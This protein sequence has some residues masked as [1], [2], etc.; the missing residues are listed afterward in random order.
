MYAL[1]EQLAGTPALGMAIGQVNQNPPLTPPGQLIGAVDPWWGAG[2]FVY[3]YAAAAIPA[4]QLCNIR[5]SFQ[6]NQYRFDASPTPNVANLGGDVAVAME[7]LAAG[8][9]GWFCVAGVVPVSSTAAVA[10]AAAIGLAAAGQLGA[11]SAGKQLLNASCLGSSATT[12]VKAN[13][14]A[15]PGTTLLQ[16]PNSDGWFPGVYLSGTGIAAGTTVLSVDGSGRYVTLSTATTASVAGSVTATYNNAVIFYNLVK[17]N[18]SFLQG[19]ITCS[20]LGRFGK[21]PKRTR[22]WGLFSFRRVLWRMQD[23]TSQATPPVCH[24]REEDRGGSGRVRHRPAAEVQG[25]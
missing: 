6:T 12:V 8:Q 22:P 4:F 14:I 17:L 25:H 21:A 20:T 1:L 18:R 3:A 9:Y 24:L 7:A 11:N 19:A 2:E 15:A 16:V 5:P 23:G 13:C 10:A